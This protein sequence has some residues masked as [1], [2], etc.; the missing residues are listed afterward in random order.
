LRVAYGSD[1]YCCDERAI[2]PNSRQSSLALL[3]I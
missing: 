3:K 2:E 1:G